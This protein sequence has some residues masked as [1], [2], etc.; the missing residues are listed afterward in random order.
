LSEKWRVQPPQLGHRQHRLFDC[1][2]ADLVADDRGSGIAEQKV[3][4]AGRRVERVS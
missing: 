3:K 1:G 4:L 2:A